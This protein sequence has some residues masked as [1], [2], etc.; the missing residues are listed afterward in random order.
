MDPDTRWTD[1]AVD[2]DTSRQNRISL[3]NI[4][5]LKDRFR[6]KVRDKAGGSGSRETERERKICKG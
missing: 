1:A 6:E 4:V 2:T 5:L 3:K